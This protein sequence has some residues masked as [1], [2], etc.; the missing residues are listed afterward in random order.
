MKRTGDKLDGC[1]TFYKK[2][3]FECVEVIK[4]PYCHSHGGSVLDRDN[5]GLILKL[6]PCTK[7][8]DEYKRLVVANTHLLFNPKRG[9]VKLAQLMVLLAEL[10]KCSYTGG[11]PDP[12]QA[13]IMCGDFNSEPHS[14]IY[15]LVVMG[16]LEYEGL[17]I[18]EISG[19]E[20]G[21]YGYGFNTLRKDFFPSEVGISD[22]C[23][24]CDISRNTWQAEN[25][26]E[27]QILDP[28]G[29]GVLQHQLR[30]ISV[31]EHWLSR[32]KYRHREI[33]THHGRAACTLDYMFY[34]IRTGQVRFYHGEVQTRNIQEGHLHLLARY[35]LLSEW[36]LGDMGSLPNE[37]YGSDHIS[38]IARFLM[39]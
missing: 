29:S 39:T 27:I 28:Q 5:V 33:T 12:Y 3:K 4:V 7:S 23:R 18:R 9:D 8:L 21:R 26:D 30:M 32:L 13:V 19:Q 17:L 31:Y 34:G 38:L 1:A 2:N 22:Y 15:K 37:R 11:K 25:D 20:E 6:S 36:E 10:D 35:G 14:D 24:Y 16:Y